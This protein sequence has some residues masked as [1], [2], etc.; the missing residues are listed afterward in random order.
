MVD[1]VGVAV[2]VAL[3]DVVA[4]AVTLAVTELDEVRLDVLVSVCV[5]D[6]VMV[7]EEVQELV[8]ERLCVGDSVLVLVPEFVD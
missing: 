8:S 4:S 5:P 6:W 7:I 1:P 3:E 2:T